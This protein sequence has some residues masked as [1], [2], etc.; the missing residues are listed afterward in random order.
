MKCKLP[1]IFLLILLISDYPGISFSQ[2]VLS[3]EDLMFLPGSWTGTLTYLD[4]TTGKPYSMPADVEIVKIDSMRKYI[5]K[6]IYPDE[7]QA[8]SADTVTFSFDGTMINDE[9]VISKK[10]LQNDAVEFK[11]ELD[12]VDGNESKPALI[13]HTYTLGEEILIIRKDVKFEDQSDWINRHEFYF[14]RS[15]SVKK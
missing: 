6:R 1:L 10:Y 3:D 9:T 8:N 11:T 4:Y 14:K 13:R 5:F 12:G 2:E 7:P 15:D